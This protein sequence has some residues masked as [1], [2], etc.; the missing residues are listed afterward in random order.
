MKTKK[1]SRCMAAFGP[2][3]VLTAGLALMAFLAA[4]AEAQ[5]QIYDLNTA[6]STQDIQ[7]D[8]TNAVHLAWTYGG[9]LYYSRIVNN[10]IASKETIGTGFYTI[11]WRPYISVKPDGSSVHV[12]WVQGGGH[13]NNIQH[14]WRNAQGWH[15]ET[16]LT[17]PS[18]QWLSQ[19]TC[20]VD[21]SGVVHVM[22]CIWND[23]AGNQW[24][25]LYY[26]RKL[27]GGQ[28][29][30][31]QLFAPKTV[32]YK[33][34]MIFTD[35]RGNVHATWCLAGS[36]GG[37]SYDAYYCTAPSGG[38]LMGATTYKIPK[39]PIA[40]VNA[41]GDIYVD[42]NGV[43]HRSIGAWSNAAQTM[44]IDHSKKLPGGQFSVPT[45]AS[46]D[47]LSGLSEHADP[48]PAVVA[49]E[50]GSV[51]VAWG[52][53]MATGANLVRASFYD[54]K[55]LGWSIYT[56]DPAAGIPDRPNAYKVALTRNNI[57][58]YGAWR[59]G[60]GHLKLFVLPILSG[61]TLQ[62]TSPNGGEKWQAG[63]SQNITWSQNGL[64][65]NVTVD[66]YK[67]G[68]KAATIATAAVS[69][70][71]YR[72]TI[73]RTTMAGTDYKIRIIQGSYADNSNGNFTI[74]EAY[75]PRISL[76]RTVLTFGAETSGVWTQGQT[77]L[78]T[79]AKGGRLNWTAAPSQTWI[80]VAPAAG[81]GNAL[82]T[83]G[84]KPTGLSVGTY[85]GV[86]SISDPYAIN[87]PQNV[88][89]TLKVSQSTA[90]P[91]G[92]FEVPVSG[93]RV[94]GTIPLSGWALDDIEV[95]KVQI[96]R[97]SV[98][99]DPAGN[100][101]ADG[102]VFVGDAAFVDGARPD[103]E[104]THP[105]YPLK[106][107]AGW[108]Y[109]LMTYGLP[110]MGN[111]TFVLHAVAYDRENNRVDLGMK[112]IIV[113]DKYNTKPFG[114]IDKPAWGGTISGSSYVNT[115]WMLTPP[116]KTIPKT[117]YSIWVWIDGVQIGH[118]VYNQYRANIALAFPTFKN[119]SGA[120]GTFSLVP[121]R[122][123]NGLHTIKWVAR[124]SAGASGDTGTSY[125]TVLNVP[126][127]SFSAS[128]TAEPESTIGI[129][130]GYN[131]SS[132]LV[133]LPV[134][135]RSPAYARTGFSSEGPFEAVFPDDRG[136]LNIDVEIDDRVELRMNEAEFPS[137][138]VS[139]LPET[140]DS[141]TVRF[142]GYL[143]VGDDLRPLP[144]GSTM[145]ANAGIFS[146]QPGPGF[147]GTYNLV[148]IRLDSGLPSEKRQVMIRILAGD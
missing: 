45:R 125:F 90:G 70:G 135:Y 16:V 126:S 130:L 120:G 103:I 4:P 9:T 62:I 8:N 145:D 12:T 123:V 147:L 85:T 131:Q 117:G 146:W 28:W 42:H 99:S 136:A 106:Q 122:Y 115:G 81:T 39:G 69:A 100:I 25:G 32:E 109:M 27:A 133:G 92:A 10:A 57:N 128:G 7:T 15:S 148:F 110:G 105:S 118:P 1:T 36:A 86:I 11:Y 82:L 22:Y 119:K 55:T 23:V 14:S 116:P 108:G 94:K 71:T 93:A 41:Y 114:L 98:R 101:G 64:S 54:P 134:D 49:H 31:A 2:G 50:D 17:A 52:Q 30:S 112:T 121:T 5:Y 37:D 53:V 26:R 141:R 89:V 129:S 66:L 38:T 18:T 124:D 76:S 137:P 56:I 138:G 96:R 34:P 72:W 127:P 13:G 132:E 104:T 58:I 48:V 63:S 80:T 95:M 78:L 111:G 97:V 83:I 79:D 40:N 51:I 91:V 3:L 73:P 75:S 65:G 43:V 19:P 74:L 33:F 68:V 61:P 6:V 102:L 46:L 29:E 144:V 143:V 24:N 140:R 67:G 21:S 20:A 87:T 60:D 113:S 47:L 142:E 77:V 84:V 88:S 107:R 44:A 59:A 35:W 139:T